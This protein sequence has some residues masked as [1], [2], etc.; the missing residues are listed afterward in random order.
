MSYNGE[1]AALATALC[2]AVSVIY[3]RKLGGAFNPLSLNL[4]KGVLSIGGL[5]LLLVFNATRLPQISTILW[6]LL[7][8]F[9]GIGIGDTA[10]FSAL[11]RM[12]ER[13]TLLLAETLAPV[14]TAL[15]AMFWINEWLSVVQWLAIA[16][17]LFGVDIVVRAK[18]GRKRAIDF[19]PGGLGFAALAA[20]CQAVGAVI[21]RDMLVSESV[22]VIS[23]SLIRLSGGLIFI[24]PVLCFS[25]Q[26]WLPQVQTQGSSQAQTQ[27]QIW[28][29]LLLATFIGTFIAMTLQMYAFANAQAAIVQS[30]F[31]SSVIISLILGKL[32]GQ[33]TS[34]KAWLGSGIAVLGVF[35]VFL[36]P[37]G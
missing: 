21:G 35:L 28:R 29:W 16:I 3:F 36:G 31:A 14:F 20:L 12:G 33:A 22:D 27:T 18:K 1:V 23:A 5:T 34:T 11:N 24:L 7:S 25:R 13:A 8:G 4:W 30:L 6:L 17:I 19:N 37:P 9:I 26:R 15:L 32:Q 2:W 10:F